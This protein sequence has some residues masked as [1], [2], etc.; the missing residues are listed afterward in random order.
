MRR[1]PSNPAPNDGG[2]ETNSAGAV[3]PNPARVPG[4][5]N[6]DVT[7][8]NIAS[9]ICT[10]DWTSTV[11]PP[12]TYTTSL[13]EQQLATGY[14]YHGDTNPGDYEEDHLIPLELGGSPTSPLNLW[15]E[16]YKAARGAATKDQIENKLNALVCDRE[17][18]LTVAQRAIAANW[19][20]AYQTYLG[21]PTTGAPSVPPTPVPSALSAP[22]TC[23]AGMSNS[24]PTDYSTVDVI[25]DTGLRGAYVTATAHYRTTDTTHSR[26][27]ASNGVAVI[28]FDISRA[29]VGYRV[30]VDVAV[31]GAGSTRSC[32]TAFT[33]RQA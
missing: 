16:P 15:P 31:S 6:P 28:L 14:A 11:R 3:L 18:T 10:S 27:A 1:P 23:S 7:Q 29:T 5:D 32:S 8:A 30:P 2:D 21:V 20:V 24:S 33:P 19:F 9:T 4:A 12:S 17:V 22:L 13:K 25:V 26:T